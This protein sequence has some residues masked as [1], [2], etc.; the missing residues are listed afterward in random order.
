M[1]LR[2]RNICIYTQVFLCFLF[3]WFTNSNTF[4]Q[5]VTEGQLKAGFVY[6][7]LKYIDWE[8]E[9]KIDTF[10][11]AVLGEDYDFVD[12]LKKMN[13][14]HVKNKPIKVFTISSI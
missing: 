10:K 11:V 8:N 4:S 6:S 7:F 13:Y 3:S 1:F 2:N 12:L 9:N 5:S 14:L